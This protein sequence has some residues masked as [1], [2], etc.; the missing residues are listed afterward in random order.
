NNTDFAQGALIVNANVLGAL[1]IA[2]NYFHPGA[3]TIK[4]DGTTVVG[5]TTANGTGFFNVTITVPITKIG[6][7]NIIIDDTKI[8]FNI[9]V[10]V[11]PTV[12]LTPNKGVPCENVQVTA[13]GYGFIASTSTK[14][15]NITLVWKWLDHG[16]KTPTTLKEKI[17]V[18]TNGYWMGTFT[19]PHS[20]GGTNFVEA[21]EYDGANLLLNITATF[22]VLPGVKITPSTFSN[23]GT[24]VTI[25]GCGLKYQYWYDLL[26]DNKDFY[27]QYNYMTSYFKDSGKG[28]FS[29]EIIA[30]GFNEKAAKHVVALYEQ[31]QS[32]ADK[33]TLPKLV[34]WTTFTVTS[35]EETAIMDKLE[36]IETA[37]SELN[38]YVTSSTT[39][40]PSIKT[41]LTAVQSAVADAKSALSTQISGLSTELT[42]ITTYAQ[43]AAT[44]AT[45]ASTSAASAAS[46]AADA[47]TAAQAA[48]SATA[49]ISTA[50]YGAIVLS[51]IAALASIVAVI[52]L[53]KKVA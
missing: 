8:I 27:T 36:E 9:S 15:Y 18:G 11:I 46:A 43:D 49:T 40:L 23:N 7:H 35:E 38:A 22:T 12:V 53:Q 4:W 2:G 16:T 34:A 3:V 42:S 41:L 21:Y 25:T 52:T 20:H 50:V 26:I 10:N 24:K 13:E 47:K 14:T 31:S 6:A 1:T 33:A 19:L 51:L 44:K 32:S 5:T 17:P 48:Q 30:A 45:S 39:G 29:L 37:I 28:D